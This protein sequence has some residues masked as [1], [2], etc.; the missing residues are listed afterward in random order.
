[1]SSA[2][3][4]LSHGHLGFAVGFL[5][6]LSNAPSHANCNISGPTT[7]VAGAQF[8][9]CADGC[10]DSCYTWIGANVV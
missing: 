9:L 7:V 1:M 8:T 6:A 2:P 3:R 10:S 4:R 5:F